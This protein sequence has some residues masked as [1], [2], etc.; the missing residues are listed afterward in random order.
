M[1]NFLFILFIPLLFNASCEEEDT[2]ED[3]SITVVYEKRSSGCNNYT[4]GP[5]EEYCVTI[6]YPKKEWTLE[7][8]ENNYSGSD[9]NCALNCCVNFQ[10][11]NSRAFYGTCA[12]VGM[13]EY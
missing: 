5:W 9:L 11:R 7:D 8:F 3:G 13:T 10:Y 1:K 6:E 12:D 2:E 4:F